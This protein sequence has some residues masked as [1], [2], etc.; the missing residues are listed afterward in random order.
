[1]PIHLGDGRYKRGVC[2]GWTMI[3]KTSL[4]HK[5][6]PTALRSSFADMSIVDDFKPPKMP[7]ERATRSFTA[8]RSTRVDLLFTMSDSLR[9]L[10]QKP[11]AR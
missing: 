2:S 10:R 7:G 4:L 6:D 5:I 9:A 8:A 1:M 3:R 11:R